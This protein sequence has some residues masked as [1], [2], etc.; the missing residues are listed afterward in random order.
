MEDRIDVLKMKA[1]SIQSDI[2]NEFLTQ[3]GYLDQCK[4]YYKAE[5]A[6]LKKAQVAGVD[7][8][9]IQLIKNRIETVKQEIVD[10]VEYMKAEAAG[11]NGT[12]E[13]AQLTNEDV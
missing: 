1:E 10:A 13:S 11:A 5:L 3:Q 9:N 8:D 7:A 12:G 6:N 2:Q 4:E